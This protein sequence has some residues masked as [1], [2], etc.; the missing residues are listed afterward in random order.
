MSDVKTKTWNYLDYV[1]TVSLA[2][3]TDN[4]PSC[5][6]MEIQKVED[7]LKCGLLPVGVLQR[8]NRLIKT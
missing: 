7:D 8:W 6:I 5:R 1:K 2:T 3:C 4:N